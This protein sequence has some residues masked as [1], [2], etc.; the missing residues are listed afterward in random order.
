[1]LLGLLIRI[2]SP[3]RGEDVYFGGLKRIAKASGALRGALGIHHRY[4]ERID[5]H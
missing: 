4:Y 2:V 3:K 1:M 5:G